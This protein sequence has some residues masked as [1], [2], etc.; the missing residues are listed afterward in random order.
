MPLPELQEEDELA[1]IGVAVVLVIIWVGMALFRALLWAIEFP[2]RFW[3][4]FRLRRM[5][6][7]HGRDRPQ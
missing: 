3:A 5:H 7:R 6:R 1:L 2:R 4:Q